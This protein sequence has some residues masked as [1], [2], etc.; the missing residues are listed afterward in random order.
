MKAQFFLCMLIISGWAF[1]HWIDWLTDR[2]IKIDSMILSVAVKC[3]LSVIAAFCYTFLFMKVF[4][5][6]I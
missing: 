4:G 1:M 3:V 5:W 6:N 2:F